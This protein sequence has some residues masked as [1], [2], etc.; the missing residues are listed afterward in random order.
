MA[1][2]DLL[3]LLTNIRSRLTSLERRLTF[4][5]NQSSL[6]GRLGPL[7]K[8]FSGTSFNSLTE[9]G[10]YRG[11]NTLNGPG[12]TGWWYVQVESHSSSWIRQRAVAYTG[13]AKEEYVRQ[14]SS[15]TWQPWERHYNLAADVVL[16]GIPV[17]SITMFGGTAIPAGYLLCAGQSAT[18]TTYPALF[19][20]IGTT[21]GN[22]YANSFTL[23]DLRGRAPVGFDSTQTEFDAMGEKG[24]AKTHTL[25]IAE[26]PSHTHQIDRHDTG[27]DQTS[28][29][30]RGYVTSGGA[31]DLPTLA[32]G[33]GGA[34]L[35]LQP[36]ITLNFIIK[37]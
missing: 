25:T 30:N 36:Y 22:L 20:V 2:R 9:N 14:F 23:P 17:G 7:S 24:G 32:T 16:V 12:G 8:D 5:S 18:R 3:G 15:S 26:M 13:A 31:N 35:N 28:A 27:A 4:A 37:T 10:W 11:A 21:Y 6:F 1:D 33:G 19:G 29:G 34:H